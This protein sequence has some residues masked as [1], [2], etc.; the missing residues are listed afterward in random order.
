MK[1]VLVDPFQIRLF[2]CNGYMQLGLDHCFIDLGSNW[3]VSL[4]CR[5]CQQISHIMVQMLK[6]LSKSIL[7]YGAKQFIRHVNPERP[8]Q[9]VVAADRCLNTVLM[10]LDTY[11]SLTVCTTC[12]LLPS[13][14]LSSVLIRKH[15]C[16]GNKS[17]KK[18]WSV[19]LTISLQ[20]CI[21]ILHVH[22]CF[23]FFLQGVGSF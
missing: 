22:H 15:Y 8:L 7:G 19:G 18:I 14:F 5:T 23:I 2:A 13:I 6:W 10:Q 21:V 4:E 17:E 9:V 3:L 1:D 16:L 20:T 12:H 11:R